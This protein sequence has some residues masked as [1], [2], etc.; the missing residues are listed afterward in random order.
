M[1]IDD[2]DDFDWDSDNDD[3]ME[4]RRE[5]E[6]E[7]RR[8]NNLPVMRKAEEILELTQA[9]V[10]TIDEERDVLLLREQMLSNAMS[11]MP[12]IAGAEA[13]DFYTARMENAVLI[14]IYSR[15]LLTQ[16]ALC[17]VEKLSNSH[18]LQLLRDEIEVF[19]QLFVEW[20]SSFDK[21]NDMA[22]N[23]GLFS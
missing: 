5:M 6:E 2:F 10:E 13:A 23:W 12:K 11:L 14:K 7:R 17:K 8:V 20:V 1:G 22:D 16:T 3:N 4:I 9:I 15:E 18:Y 21:T 19:R